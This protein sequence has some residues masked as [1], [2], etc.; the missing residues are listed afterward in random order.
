MRSL[1]RPMA[2]EI[3]TALIYWVDKQQLP[4]AHTPDVDVHEV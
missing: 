3:N 1:G 4:M 2:H